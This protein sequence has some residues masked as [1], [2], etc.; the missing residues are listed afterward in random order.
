MFLP[1]ADVQFEEVDEL[2]DS[3]RLS[4][5]FGSSGTK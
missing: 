5:G 1:I 3:D 4:G 2:A